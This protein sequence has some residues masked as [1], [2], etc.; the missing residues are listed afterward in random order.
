[1][2]T[3]RGYST[4]WLVHVRLEEHVLA[5][6]ARLDARE[7]ERAREPGEHP[8]PVA[9]EARRDEDE[10]LVDEACLEER[11]SERRTALEEQRLD[12]VGRELLELLAERSR[13]ELELGALGQRAAP[14]RDPARL[15][16]DGNVARVETWVVPAHRAHPD[17]DRVRLR[18]EHVDEPARLLAR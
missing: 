10:Q 5:D 6:R 17:G 1:M 14:E 3:V 12:A 15:P 11:C 8:R 9:G 7:L 4:R 2:N 13:A 18:A 16:H